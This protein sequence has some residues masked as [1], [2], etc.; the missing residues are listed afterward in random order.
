M[1]PAGFDGLLTYVELS[2]TPAQQIAAVSH[3]LHGLSPLLALFDPTH[4]QVGSWLVGFTISLLAGSALR[5]ANPDRDNQTL[6]FATLLCCNSLCNAYTPIYDLV[7]LFR[8]RLLNDRLPGIN[9]P[10]EPKRAFHT[11][12]VGIGCHLL[13]PAPIAGLSWSAGNSTVR[14]RDDRGTRRSTSVAAATS[15]R[16]RTWQSVGDLRLRLIVD[17]P[18]EARTRGTGLTRP[19]GMCR[20][21]PLH[22]TYDNIRRLALVLPRST[23]H[24][25]PTTSSGCHDRRR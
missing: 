23:H 24:A 9:E 18:V 21:R 19:S 15:K 12:P 2:R 7:L 3:K 11:Q 25:T 8:Q 20:L 4:A 5:N 22:P 14:R 13:R 10:R 6:W 1:I 16:D 17:L